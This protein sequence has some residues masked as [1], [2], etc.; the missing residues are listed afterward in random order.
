MQVGGVIGK[1]GTIV[2]QVREETGA[3]IRVVEGV[4]NCDER[5]IVISA[6]N[7]AGRPTHAAQVLQCWLC[8]HLIGAALRTHLAGRAQPSDMYNVVAQQDFVSE[9]L[10]SVS[11]DSL[12]SAAERAARELPAGSPYNST[13]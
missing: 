9:D 1:A 2:K 4:P 12:C 8:M 5:V 10:K 11:C 13:D 7:Q 3:R 6:P